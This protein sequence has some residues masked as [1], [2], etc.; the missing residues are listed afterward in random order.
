LFVKPIPRSSTANPRHNAQ[1]IASTPLARAC[2]PADLRHAPSKNHA[3]VR[4][5]GSQ[6]DRWAPQIRA[7]RALVNWSAEDLSHFAQG[8]STLSSIPARFEVARTHVDIAVLAQLQEDD[9]RARKL[10]RRHSYIHKAKLETSRRVQKELAAEAGLT[11]PEQRE[12]YNTRRR[13][14]PSGR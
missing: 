2:R 7:A 8:L 6:R 11:L 13:Q 14:V 5:G 12:G 4:R 3:T 1:M 10:P 9:D